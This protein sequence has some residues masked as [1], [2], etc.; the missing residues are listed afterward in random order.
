MLGI[1]P[2]W[3]ITSNVTIV[4]INPHDHLTQGEGTM[5]SI[6]PVLKGLLIDES[7]QDLIEYA[8]IAALIA[9]GAI[10]AMGGLSNQIANEFNTIGN[11]L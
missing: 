2:L 5:Q 3:V 9:L 6:T 11:T 8:L 7:G 1:D 4:V 10:V